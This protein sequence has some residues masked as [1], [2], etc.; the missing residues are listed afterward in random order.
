MEQG[1]RIGCRGQRLTS[2]RLSAYGCVI[3][4]QLCKQNFTGLAFRRKRLSTVSVRGVG[5]VGGGGGVDVRR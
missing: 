5:V 4:A 1:R 2:S 3:H